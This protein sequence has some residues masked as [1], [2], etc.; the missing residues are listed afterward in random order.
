[1]VDYVLLPQNTFGVLEMGFEGIFEATIFFSYF[2]PTHQHTVLTL[3]FKKT[4]YLISKNVSRNW[5]VTQWCAT[6]TAVLQAL[7]GGKTVT[8][9]I[10]SSV[11]VCSN[12]Q[13]DLRVI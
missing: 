3:S 11:A 12:S 9:H 13:R 10:A 5:R 8:H 1:M 2:Y 7:R 6:D 4:L